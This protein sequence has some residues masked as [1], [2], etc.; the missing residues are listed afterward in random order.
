MYFFEGEDLLFSPSS[1]RRPWQENANQEVSRNTIS[2]EHLH[3]PF[4][5]ICKPSCLGMRREMANELPASTLQKKRPLFLSAQE[6][7]SSVHAPKQQNNNNNNNCWYSAKAT[8]IDVINQWEW[9][10]L[11]EGPVA[12][13]AH[14]ECRWRAHNC[15]WLALWKNLHGRTSAI[16]KK[17]LY[18]GRQ[19]F[20]LYLVSS[21]SLHWLVWHRPCFTKL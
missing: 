19:S 18:S 3:F 1:T 11:C 7:T 9:Q 8:Q 4:A 17:C 12:E 14:L 10:V 21:P 5:S 6:N 20:C 2:I 15:T 13:Q 16:S